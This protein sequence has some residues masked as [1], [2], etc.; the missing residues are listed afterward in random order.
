MMRNSSRSAVAAI[1]IASSIAAAPL[2]AQNYPTKPV[3]IITGSSGALGD[4]IARQIAARLHERWGQPAVVENRPGAGL[5]IGTAIVAK[6]APDGYTLIMS[7]RTAL[8]SAPSL[9]QNLAYDPV[10]DLAPITLVATSPMVLIAHMSVPAANLREF[11]AYVKHLPQGMTHGTGGPGTVNHLA[12]ELMKQLTG[13]NLVPVHYK[14]TGAAMVAIL[15]AEVK[16]GFSVPTIALPHLQA[17]KV[18]AYVVT[19]AKRLPGAPDVPTVGEAGVP[20]LESEY[21]IG[22]LAPARTPPTLVVRLNRDF[23]EVLQTPAVRGVLLDQGSEPRPGTP[24]E[25]AAFIKSETVK[26]GRVIKTAG[27]KPE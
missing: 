4:I 11:V 9:Y 18:K 16:A 2:L 26:W 24:E 5:T 17:G 10:K 13:A 15:G 1:L 19:G 7:D 3:R 21:W 12:G 22:M 6:A 14:G 25:F 23:I 20:D 27:L 8:A